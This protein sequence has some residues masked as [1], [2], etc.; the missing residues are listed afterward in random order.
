M[1]LFFAL[2]PPRETA[3]ALSGWAREVARAT[4]GRATP[5]EKIHLTL[6]F[7]GGVDPARAA[8]AAR[9]VKAPS[10]ELPLEQAKYWGDNHILWAGPRE[11]PAALRSLVER[12][13]LA[14]HRA[15][16]ILEPRSFA[17]HVT[18]VRKGRAPR[19]LPPLPAVQWP[20]HEFSLVN[21]TGGDYQDLERFRLAS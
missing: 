2:W 13:Q 21:S 7:L 17:A 10:F 3:A 20:V 19:A 1:R 4:S 12:L 15:Q 8:A 18:L 16:F 11:I 6:T 9:P 14:L 5:P